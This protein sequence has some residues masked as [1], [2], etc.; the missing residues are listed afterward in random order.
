MKRFHVPTAEELEKKRKEASAAFDPL[1]IFHQKKAALEASTPAES[2]SIGQI[3]TNQASTS[4]SIHPHPVATSVD[5]LARSNQPPP[6]NATD[7]ANSSASSVPNAPIAAPK[8]SSPN[9][10]LVNPCQVSNLYPFSYQ[11]TSS[12]SE[13]IR[14]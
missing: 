5:N 9:N 14:S 7:P 4:S 3:S 1:S 12:D 8:R 10:I 2:S 13:V 11:L 6:S